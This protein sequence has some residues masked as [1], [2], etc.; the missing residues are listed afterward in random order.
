MLGEMSHW[1]TEA[2]WGGKERNM[3]EEADAFLCDMHVH[4]CIHARV[5][6]VQTRAE[7]RKHTTELRMNERVYIEIRIGIYEG[8]EKYVM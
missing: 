1:H 7:D 6:R 5:I 2:A 8:K 4:I 3:K